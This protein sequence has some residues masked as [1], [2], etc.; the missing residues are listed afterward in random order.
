MKLL[1]RSEQLLQTGLAALLPGPVAT[2]SLSVFDSGICLV[3]LVT[4]RDRWESTSQ[5]W[6]E[7]DTEADGP[8]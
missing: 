1:R 6:G 5:N 3:M 2:L 8:L 4:K 7:E